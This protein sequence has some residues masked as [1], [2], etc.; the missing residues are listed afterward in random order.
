MTAMM[1]RAHEIH[2]L[3]TFYASV[4]ERRPHK[5]MMIHAEESARD[6]VSP[7]RTLAAGGPPSTVVPPAV[8]C[9][10]PEWEGPDRRAAREP[11]AHYTPPA[12]PGAPASWLAPIGPTVAEIVLRQSTRDLAAHQRDM[13]RARDYRFETRLVEAVIGIL[14]S[15]TPERAVHLLGR[16][17]ARLMAST[18]AEVTGGSVE[19]AHG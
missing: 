15:V 4:G 18:S 9:G 3:A 16:V 6:R 14:S 11:I 10:T 1:T 5:D 12:K 2:E 19:V 8:G 13:E 17:H 7:P